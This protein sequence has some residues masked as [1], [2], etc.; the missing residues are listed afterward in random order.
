MWIFGEAFVRNSGHCPTWWHVT[1]MGWA[2]LTEQPSAV[3][4]W[5]AF[6]FKEQRLLSSPFTQRELGGG[7]HRFK[8][9][10][11]N[12]RLQEVQ[13]CVSIQV[14]FILCF[15]PFQRNVSFKILIL[16]TS[17]PILWF[18]QLHIEMVSAWFHSS[19][20]RT[21]ALPHSHQFLIFIMRRREGWCNLF[22]SGYIWVPPLFTPL[23]R[24]PP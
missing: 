4:Y 5:A 11:F 9:I 16:A 6:S 7:G 18:P 8:Q 20:W 22:L 23:I 15:T 10:W 14:S 3:F 21:T 13:K 1:F 24:E 19:F 2:F 12:L 17:V